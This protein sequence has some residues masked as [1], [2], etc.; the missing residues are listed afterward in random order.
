MYFFF[1][2]FNWTGQYKLPLECKSIFE[3]GDSGEQ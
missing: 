2:D 1:N 3:S